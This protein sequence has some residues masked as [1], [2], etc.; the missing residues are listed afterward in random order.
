MSKIF[1]LGLEDTYT[2][3]QLYQLKPPTQQPASYTF[4]PER[5]TEIT[6]DF[7]KLSTVVDQV[8]LQSRSADPKAIGHFVFD[9]A[10]AVWQKGSPTPHAA[11]RVIMEIFPTVVH[12]IPPNMVEAMGGTGLVV[13]ANLQIKDAGGHTYSADGAIFLVIARQDKGRASPRGYI[14][15]FIF[16]KKKEELVL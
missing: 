15:W 12:K 11:A 6:G 3:E 16:A 9:K 4:N 1:V 14:K 5:F 8:S 7:W 2:K 13:A 10:T